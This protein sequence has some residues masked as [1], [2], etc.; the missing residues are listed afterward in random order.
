MIHFTCT[1]CHARLSVSDDKAGHSGNCP[2]CGCTIQVPAAVKERAPL[3]PIAKSIEPVEEGGEI[4]LADEPPRASAS[5]PSRP[6]QAP[7][8]PSRPVIAEALAGEGIESG[9]IPSTD[10]SRESEKEASPEPEPTPAGL[11][12]APVGDAIA[13]SFQKSKILE[14]MEIEPIGHELY[15]LVDQR[16]CRKIV[17]DFSN[18][19]FLSSQMLGVLM[20]LQKKSAAIKGRVVLCGLSSDLQKLF[21][22]MNLHK[23]LVIVADRHTALGV[24]NLPA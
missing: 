22:I 7:R 23:V 21:K 10:R 20:L 4:P 14:A 9:D 11:V 13:V 8:V 2:K 12:I 18:V 16:A 3:K 19:K 17:L 5:T 6:Q 15:A 1:Q 24:V